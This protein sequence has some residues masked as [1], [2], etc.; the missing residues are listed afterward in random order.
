MNYKTF[1]LVSAGCLNL[2]G[3]L[4]AWIQIYRLFVSVDLEVFA[5]VFLLDFAEQSTGMAHEH[6]NDVST[7]GGIAVYQ[8]SD[9]Q[10]RPIADRQVGTLLKNG[11]DLAFSE[12]SVLRLPGGGPNCSEDSRNVGRPRVLR[13]CKS[14]GPPGSGPS[15]RTILKW[16]GGGGFAFQPRVS[17]C[18]VLPDSGPKLRKTLGAAALHVK[19]LPIYGPP[20]SG[21]KPWK[22]C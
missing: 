5:S 19:C 3:L 8:P 12:S 4:G 2:E 17:R 9:Y 1:E 18:P 10:V 13:F 7:C 11:C 22:T 14:A 16:E 6:R 20:A 15:K 21:P